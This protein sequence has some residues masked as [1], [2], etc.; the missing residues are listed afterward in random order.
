MPNLPEDARKQGQLR[1][2]ERLGQQDVQLHVYGKQEARAFRKMR[3]FGPSRF[4]PCGRKERAGG[5]RR[6]DLFAPRDK[7][8]E[9]PHDFIAFYYSTESHYIFYKRLGA[10]I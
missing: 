6:S 10:S 2:E 1:C 8:R 5:T 4:A 9:A 3:T 7:F